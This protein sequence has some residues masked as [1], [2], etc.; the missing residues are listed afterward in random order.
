MPEFIRIGEADPDSNQMSDIVAIFP[1]RPVADFLTNV[2]FKHA[3]SFYYY[4]D[5]SW[6][7][8]ILDH[9]YLDMA[10]LR[11]KDFVAICV[12]LMVLAVGT[13]YVHLE[14]PKHHNRRRTVDIDKHNSWELEIG[15]AFYRQ[16][17]KLT[18]E[19]IH[20]GSLLS[21]QVFLLLGLY[22]LPI[23]ASGIG[24]IYLNLAI[25][26]AIQNGL[27]RKVPHSNFDERTKEIRRRVWWT[28]YCMERFVFHFPTLLDPSTH[29]LNQQKDRYISWPSSIHRTLRYRRRPAAQI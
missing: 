7:D 19:V 5:Q 20:A 3:T 25:K 4:V 28:A 21:V 16:V 23:D 22:S 1:P 29:S 2:F 8:G 15:S 13:Q 17:V 11:S 24:Y 12:I 27:H 18:S 10:E 9:I 26:V 14:T 6:F